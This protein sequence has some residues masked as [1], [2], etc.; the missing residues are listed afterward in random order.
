VKGSYGRVDAAGKELLS[1]LV[2]RL[3]TGVLWGAN[4]GAPNL[5]AHSGFSIEGCVQ[6]NLAD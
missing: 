1:A 4:F 5:G 6:K 2:E 3:G